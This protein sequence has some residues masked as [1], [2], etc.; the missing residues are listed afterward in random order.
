[1]RT[2]IL[3]EDRPDGAVDV[4]VSTER[5]ISRPVREKSP[6][7]RLASQTYEWIRQ[8]TDRGGRHDKARRN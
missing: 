4:T 5:D 2:I 8:N 6:A 1:M 7:E 3:I